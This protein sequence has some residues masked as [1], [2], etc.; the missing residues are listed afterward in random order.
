MLLLL[1][2]IFGLEA[3]HIRLT[4]TLLLNVKWIFLSVAASIAIFYIQSYIFAKTRNFSQSIGFSAIGS[5]GGFV[6]LFINEKLVQ[7]YPYSQPMIAL[8]SRAIQDF[9]LDELIIFIVVNLIFSIIFYNLSCIELEK[10]K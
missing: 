1:V 5:M 3:A 4:P 9:S 10:T 2:Y 8:R 7:F 6:L